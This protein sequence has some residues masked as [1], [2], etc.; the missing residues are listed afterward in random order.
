MTPEKR[1]CL[2]ALVLTDPEDD[3]NALKRH[4]TEHAPRTCSWILDTTE[5]QE[6]IGVR[7]SMAQLSLESIKGGFRLNLL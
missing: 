6:W 7:N 1:L 3:K 5:L 4:K 2:Q